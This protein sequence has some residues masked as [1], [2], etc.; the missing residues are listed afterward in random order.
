M[1]RLQPKRQARCGAEGARRVQNLGAP[2]PKMRSELCA[3]FCATYEPA[4]QARDWAEA[5]ACAAGS[6]RSLSTDSQ[7]LQN[8]LEGI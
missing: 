2:S 6:W 1:G 5:L 3:P 7:T 8:E 4:A